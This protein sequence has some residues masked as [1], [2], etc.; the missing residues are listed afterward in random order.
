MTARSQQC[1]VLHVAGLQLGVEVERVQ[2]VLG[3][4]PVTPVPLA[5]PSVAGLLNLRGR[6]VTAVDARSR[7]GLPP[8]PGAGTGTN[9]VMTAAG[10]TVSL[11]VDREG[12]VVDVDGRA[13]EPVPETVPSSIRAFVR[14]CYQLDAALLLIVDADRVFGVD[15]TV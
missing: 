13:F 11:I 6:I 7:L 1:C 14:G 2:E 3:D 5:D 4:A 9:V 12:D 15:A 10:E 8:R